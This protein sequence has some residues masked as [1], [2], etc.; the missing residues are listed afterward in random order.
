MPNGGITP[1]CVH[2]QLYRGQPHTEDEPYCEHH[3]VRLPYP[4][5]AFCAN[6]VD[7]EPGEGMDWLDQEL[8]RTQLQSDMMYLWLG[9]H[10]KRFFHVPLALIKDYGQWTRERFLEGLAELSEKYKED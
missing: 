4:I 5:R 6:F 3:N 2:C 7:P 1:D 9:G 8:D 10:E